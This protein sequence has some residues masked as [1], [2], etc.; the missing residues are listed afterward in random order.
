MISEG[1]EARG[2]QRAPALDM[3]LKLLDS[4]ERT[5]SLAIEIAAA[6]ALDIIEGA[7]GPGADL[8]SVDLANRFATSRTPVREALGL[9]EREGLVEMT[10]R[11]RPRVAELS[12]Q[13]VA[14]IYALRGTL[15]ALV[16][17]RVARVAT[18]VQLDR[19]AELLGAMETAERAGDTNA[20]F[21]AVFEFQE[22]VNTVA[23]DGI[24]ARTVSSLG[25]RVLQ[26]RHRSL[27][28]EGRMVPSLLDHT[29]LLRA[30]RERD[31]DLA[32]AITTSIVRA[33]FQALCRASGWDRGQ[34]DSWDA[35][36]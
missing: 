34:F 12:P 23:D 28:I 31:A 1:I 21:W 19:L 29:R 30:F 6:V 17:R 5:N 2:E 26:L 8:N 24:L 27:S 14:G 20:Y 3:L 16:A 9:L 7:L 4:G 18:D 15:H 32:S 33:A 10:A 35:L 11:R 22:Q 13:Q 36:A 25:L